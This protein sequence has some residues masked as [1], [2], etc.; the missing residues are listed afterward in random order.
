[1]LYAATRAS[2]MKS[3]GSTAF[4]DSIFATSRADITPDAYTAH[5]KHQSAPQ[6]LSKREQE[7]ADVRAAER[8]AGAN[9][10]QGSRARQ[11][12][13]GSSQVGFQWTDEVEQAL[14][15]LR[16]GSGAAL[17]VIVSYCYLS[18]NEVNVY[19]Y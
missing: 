16:D 19:T 15:T 1:M 11:N 17:V 10:Y 12:H 6:P 9:P 8:E 13:L 3:L 7:L 4:T 2:L 5:L 14:V 18:K